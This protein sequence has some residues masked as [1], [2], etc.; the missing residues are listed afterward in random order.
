MVMHSLRSTVVADEP[1]V[2]RSRPAPRSRRATRTSAFGVGRR[3]SHDASGFYA[4]FTQPE[5]TNNATIHRVP[6]LGDGCLIGDSRHMTALPDSSVA[7]VVTSPPYFVGKEYEDAIGAGVVPESYTEFLDLLRAVF[8]ECKRVLEPGGRIAVNVANLGRKP[9]RSLSGDV[10]RILQ[11]DLGLL[12]RGEIIWRKAKGTSGSCAWGSYRQASNPVLRDTT[13]RIVVASKGRFDRALSTAE[14]KAAGYPHESTMAPDEFMEAT[15][16]VWEIDAESARR[17]GHPAPFPVELPRRLIDL[18]T[19]VGDVVL[20]P[21]LGSGSTV[22]AAAQARRRGVGYDLDPAYVAIAKERVS[23]ASTAINESP[24]ARDGKKAQ[25]IALRL[26]EEAGFR[27][28]ERDP[29]LGDAGVQ[30]NFRV[31]GKRAQPWLVDVAGTFTTIRPGLQ[32]AETL[33]RTLA[34]VAALAHKRDAPRVLVLTPALPKRGAEGDRA[35][36]ASCGRPGLF[37][38]IEMYDDAAVARLH[39][40]AQSSTARPRPGYWTPADISAGFG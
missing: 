2:A 36:R 33:W 13:E 34:R 29:K 35:L 14:R 19:Y 15:L 3:E 28:V 4:R 18:Y 12:L 16:D 37:D 8:A 11:D 10:I 6:D 26:L 22:V 9:Y 1:R 7:L 38:V 32:R 24:A 27:V 40:Y 21:F 20:D 31:Q 25:D 5:I 30:F 23:T 39:A 17:V